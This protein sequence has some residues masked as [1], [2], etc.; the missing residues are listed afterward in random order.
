MSKL[1]KL[2]K[3]HQ[4]QLSSKVSSVKIP[5]NFHVQIR[6]W[7]NQRRNYY[8]NPDIIVYGLIGK[9]ILSLRSFFINIYYNIIYYTIL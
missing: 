7:Y 8:T 2:S 6:N 3:F 5:N 9:I 1:S 4:L